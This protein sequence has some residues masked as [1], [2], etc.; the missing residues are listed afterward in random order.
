MILDTSVVIAGERKSFDLPAFLQ[1]LGAESVAIAAVTASELLHGCHRAHD[2]ATRIRRLA[3]VDAVLDLIPVIPFGLAE[4]RRHAD[5][6]SELSRKGKVV[7]AHDM[8]IAA[9]VL[10][11]GDRLATFNLREFRT[12][13]GLQVVNPVQLHR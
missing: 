8:L 6:W 5:V 3:F 1:S 7:G 4:A 13:P 11:A 12:V 9:T 10:A 2:A